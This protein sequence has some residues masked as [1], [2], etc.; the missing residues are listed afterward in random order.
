MTNEETQA[1]TQLIARESERN[2]EMAQRLID[3]N[4]GLLKRL[5][6]VMVDRRLC[7]LDT[8]QEVLTEDGEPKFSV[9]PCARELSRIDYCATHHRSIWNCV[10]EMTERL[11]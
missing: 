6:D 8:A 11:S 7:K 4:A 2:R 10:K 9:E 5:V 3:A 1:L